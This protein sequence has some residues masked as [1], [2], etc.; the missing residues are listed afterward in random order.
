MYGGTRVQNTPDATGFRQPDGGHADPARRFAADAAQFHTIT[1]PLDVAL[2]LKEIP[3]IGTC[4]WALI[5]SGGDLTPVAT[6]RFNDQNGEGLAVSPGMFLKGLRFDRIFLT[7]TAQAGKSLTLFYGVDTFGN[8]A[9]QNAA[10]ALA[11]VTFTKGT[12]FATAADVT[13]TTAATVQVLAANATRRYALIGNPI[14]NPMLMRIG[15]AGAAAAEGIELLPGEKI[16]LETS[17][18]IF[19]FNP[20]AVDRKITALEISD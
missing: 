3:M 11:S 5:P 15:D 1:I 19:A 4:L 9:I 12:T 18:A 8:L 7:N 17:A 10:I 6:I 13:V 20:D 2:N 16:R 14:A